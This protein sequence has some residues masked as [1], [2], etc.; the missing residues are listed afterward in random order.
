[1]LPDLISALQNGR[2]FHLSAATQNWDYLYS[3]DGAEALVALGEKGNN[4]EIYNVASG[5]Y[6]PL[7]CFTEE[8]REIFPTNGKLQY[9]K[10]EANVTSLQPSIIKIC[11]DTGWNPKTKFKD[12]IKKK[13]KYLIL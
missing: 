12:D 10:S 4:G 13:K 5:E 11:N 3:S 9:G 6:R 7:R 2:D 8:V 1:M